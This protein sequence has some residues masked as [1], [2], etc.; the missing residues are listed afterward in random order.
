ME[1]NQNVDRII[2]NSDTYVD[3]ESVVFKKMCTYIRSEIFTN[4]EI[5]SPA[6]KCKILGQLCVL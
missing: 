1:D 5:I 2:D 6:D 4:N 3:A